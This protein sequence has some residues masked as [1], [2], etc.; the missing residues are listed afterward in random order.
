V[1]LLLCN[2]PSLF[3]STSL[4]F[5]IICRFVRG[6]GIRIV[7]HRVR[8][9]MNIIYLYIITRLSVKTPQSRRG[10]SLRQACEGIRAH[11]APPQCSPQRAGCAALPGHR[12]VGRLGFSGFPEGDCKWR[13]EFEMAR[14]TTNPGAPDTG[15]VNVTS[16]TKS[17]ASSPSTHVPHPPHPLPR[18]R[19]AG[20]LPA[21]LPAAQGPAPIR[22]CSAKASTWTRRTGRLSAVSGACSWAQ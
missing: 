22:S 8:I 6:S 13:R 20:G 2:K 4:A 19:Q 12:T 1:F 18:G 5:I 3:L 7:K 14:P 9:P 15:Q 10:Q 11:L 16:L 21:P 17:L